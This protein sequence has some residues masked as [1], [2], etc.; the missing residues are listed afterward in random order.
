MASRYTDYYLRQVGRGQA[1]IGYL[2]RGRSTVQRGRGVGSFFA[3][4]LRNLRPLYI[5]F[6]I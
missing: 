5:S 2:Y 1:D 4:I 3:N 6:Y